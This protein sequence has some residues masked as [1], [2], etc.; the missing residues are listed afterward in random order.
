MIGEGFRFE[1]FDADSWIGA[2]SLFGVNRSSD[3]ARRGALVVVV[4]E[5]GRP[6][7]SFLTHRGHVSVDAWQG[8][9]GLDALCELHGVQRAVVLD[10]GAIEELTDRAA[11]IMPLTADYATQWLAI[12]S[13]TRQLENEGK[14][15]F[16]PPR[17][18]LPLPTTQMLRR[19][20]DLLLPDNHVLLL[21]IWEGHRPW[22]V[23]ALH[24]RGGDIDR[25]VGPDLVLDWAGPLGGDL[26]RDYRQVRRAVSRALGPVH[27]GVFARRD[28]IERL[29]AQPE[30]GAWA[31]AIALREV[32]ISPA[33]RYVHMAVG[34]DAARAAGKR[35][36]GFFGGLDLT[37]FLAP[38]AGFAREHI[39]QIGSVTHILGFNPLE[40]LAARLRR[41]QDD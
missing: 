33:P 31:R 11:E 7:A 24:R 21:V 30:P 8:T 19:A 22:T 9:D 36:R 4:D 5:D 34:A 32:L 28:V 16:W 10:R 25:V 18:H 12:A 41:R 23:I 29:L 17:R 26:R 38:A 27:C 39:A 14:L 37:S 2:L 1:G 3:S 40:A 15:L 20:L 35:A 13:A 6:C